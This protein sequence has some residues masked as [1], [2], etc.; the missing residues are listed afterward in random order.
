MSDGHLLYFFLGAVVGEISVF[1][2][3]LGVGIEKVDV[4]SSIFHVMFMQLV[5]SS[6]IRKV[7][8][9]VDKIRFL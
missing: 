5:S 6:L 2:K 3:G 8:F 7:F 4:V 1:E 9:L